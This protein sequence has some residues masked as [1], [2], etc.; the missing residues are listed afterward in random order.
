[1]NDVS[2]R[3]RLRV[4][5]SHLRASIVNQAVHAFARVRFAMPDADPARF[6]VAV[7]KDLPYR[8]TGDSAHTLDVYLPTRGPKPQPTILYVHGGGFSMLSKETHRVMAL[9]YARRGYL[10]FLINYRLGPKHLFPAPLE[11]AAEALLWV[12]DNCAYFGGDPSRIALA[13]ESAG[14]NLVTALTLATSLR[15][16]EPFLRKIFDANIRLRATVATYGFLDLE[17]IDHYERHP[18][19]P[20]RLKDLVLHAAASY[21]G[22]NVQSG[23]AAAPMASPL[24]VLERAA[25]LDRPL[26]PFFADAG[27]RDPLLGDSRRLKAAV[28]THGGSCQLHIAPGEI[29]GYDALVWRAPAREKWH[30]VHEFL[31]PLMGNQQAARAEAGQ[32]LAPAQPI[33]EP[34]A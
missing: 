15:R 17:S 27:T 21:V 14:G 29:H 20:S 12:R 10:V 24:L 5:R 33:F 25:A 2:L 11:D 31:A 16:P 1:M 7:Q 8:P 13:G 28:E 23:A 18:R 30:R 34:A 6:N 22:T 4:T 3:H 32:T 9:A 26:P 19:L